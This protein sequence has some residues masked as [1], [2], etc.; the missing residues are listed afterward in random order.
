MYKIY[1]FDND[2]VKNKVKL[3]KLINILEYRNIP[4]TISTITSKMLNDGYTD[5]PIVKIDNR[6]YKYT[7]VMNL[8]S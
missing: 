6:L 7:E 2:D 1:K 4:Y 5:V 8:L 3:D